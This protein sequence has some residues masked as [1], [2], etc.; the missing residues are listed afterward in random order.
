MIPG[1]GL[2]HNVGDGINFNSEI[3]RKSSFKTSL[4]IH[5]SVLYIYNTVAAKLNTFSNNP[6]C[7]QMFLI[8]ES[9]TSIFLMYNTLSV[10]LYVAIP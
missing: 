1:V 2:G 5:V 9:K 4:W 7:T 6:F 3:N 8:T 10:H